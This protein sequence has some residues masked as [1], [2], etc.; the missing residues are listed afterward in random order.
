MPSNEKKSTKNKNNQSISY[1]NNNNECPIKEGDNCK[2]PGAFND[3]E[4]IGGG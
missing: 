1:V 2:V 4:P 3:S